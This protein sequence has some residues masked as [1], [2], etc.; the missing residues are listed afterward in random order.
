MNFTQDPYTLKQEV[1]MDGR[2]GCMRGRDSE[3]PVAVDASQ[4]RKSW[5]Q[6]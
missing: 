1:P 4:E 5:G 6:H 3:K 2:A